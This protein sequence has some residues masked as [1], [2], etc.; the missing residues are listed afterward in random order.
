MSLSARNWA[1]A[2]Q[3]IR[4]DGQM[5]RL[6]PIEKFVLV[7][8]AEMENVEEGFAFPSHDTIADVIGCSVRTVQSHTATLAT[9]GAFTIEKR[10]SRSGKWFRN[11][12]VFDVP[13]RFR[14]SDPE[15]MRL[16]C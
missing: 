5:R 9:A 11:V 14:D 6:H 8:I 16:H 3:S 4:V 15:W 7:Y 10:R 2:V 1:Y 12:Y 13:Q